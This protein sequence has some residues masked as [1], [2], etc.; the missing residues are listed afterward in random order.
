MGV[1]VVRRLL[2]MIPV[3]LVVVTLV[4][5]MLHL[6]PGDPA[7]LMLDPSASAQEVAALRHQLGL[8]QPIGREY[9]E[10]LGHL[11]RGSIGVSFKTGRSAL[12]DALP[13]FQRTV[14][15][16][17]ASVV[18][19]AVLGVGLGI[20]AGAWSRSV[21]SPITM[22]VALLGVSVPTFW[23]GLLLII[24]FSL[25]LGL[26]PAGGAGSWQ[27]LVLPAVTLGSFSLG[28][29]ARITR[30]SMTEVL[31]ADYVRTARAKGA[32]ERIVI[33]RHAFRNALI[34]VITITSLSFGYALGGAVATETVFA[35]PGLGRHIV[36]AILARDY[37]SVQAGLFLF[38]LSFL[39]VNLGM[40]LAYAAVNP[41]ITYR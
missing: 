28:V 17:A 10:F 5:L 27:A 6:I 18:F 19:A 13:P 30:A 36:G 12:A 34:P 26:L 7:Q 8:D 21:L 4:F 40:D 23:L 3:V 37:P 31:H 1:Y 38:A 25:K 20:A 11:L 16:A 41:R 2:H 32:P 22:L 33:L 14:E 29:I 39:I 9:V 15:L 35:W 24:V